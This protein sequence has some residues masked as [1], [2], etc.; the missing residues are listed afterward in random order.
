MLADEVVDQDFNNTVQF[1]EGS[2]SSPPIGLATPSGPTVV[3][4]PPS[5]SPLNHFDGWTSDS[6]D[7]T[8]MAEF[9]DF[10]GNAFDDTNSDWGLDNDLA[11]ELGVDD[12]DVEDYATF[13]EL[14]G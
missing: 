12:L 14:D 11:E 13:A 8:W 1:E 3:G 9:T 4:A 7:S 2:Q 5:H 10:A 6:Q